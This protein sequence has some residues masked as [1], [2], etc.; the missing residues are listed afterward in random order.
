MYEQNKFEPI[1]T[2]LLLNYVQRETVDLV[3]DKIKKSLKTKTVLK[4]ISDLRVARAELISR[5]EKMDRNT[6]EFFPNGSLISYNEKKGTVVN[7]DSEDKLFVKLHGEDFLI[8]VEA[9]KLT[10]L[11]INKYT[12]EI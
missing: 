12:D 5:L 11:H 10:L 3:S 9:S 4:R 6:S 8:K 7:T 1:S 2:A